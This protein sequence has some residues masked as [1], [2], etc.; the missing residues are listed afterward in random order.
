LDIVEFGDCANPLQAS[1]I[2]QPIAETRNQSIVEASAIE[3]DETGAI[4][5]VAPQ[6]IQSNPATCAVSIITP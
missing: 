6:S 2:V 1:A 4:A 3:V 5:L